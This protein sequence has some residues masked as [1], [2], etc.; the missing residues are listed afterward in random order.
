MLTTSG[1]RDCWEQWLQS[2]T[3][4]FLFLI[5]KRNYFVGW[6]EQR[7]LSLLY[8][9]ILFWPLVSS[10]HTS[11]TISNSWTPV[12]SPLLFFPCITISYA[13]AVVPFCCC[14]S[15][16]WLCPCRLLIMKSKQVYLTFCMAPYHTLTHPAMHC[17]PGE[18]NE[19]LEIKTKKI[20]CKIKFVPL[21]V[22]W[23]SF[24]LCWPQYYTLKSC[25]ES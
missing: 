24:V 19:W 3:F 2:D 21:H 4:F 1:K 5:A 17:L 15:S 8:C 9:M 11:P 7:T 22:D 20:N 10:F 13:Q 6:L 18:S 23:A 16:L 12:F 25:Q 14:S